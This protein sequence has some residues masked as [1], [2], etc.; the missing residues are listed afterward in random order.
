[1]M[2]KFLIALLFPVFGYSQPTFEGVVIATPTDNGTNTSQDWTVTIAGSGFT[3]V[4]GDLVLI[5]AWQ[6]TSATITVDVTGGQTWNEIGG[7]N[8]TNNVSMNTFW[9]EYNGTWSADPSLNFSAGTNTNAIMVVFRPSDAST[10]W[11]TEQISTQN[12]SA[13]ATITMT[14]VTP[15]FN[16]SATVAAWFTADDNTWG[17]LTGTGWSKTNLSAQYRNTSG[18]DMSGTFA[19]R[20]IGTAAA[21][22]DVSQTQTAV[23]N[24]A[25]CTRRITFYESAPATRRVTIIS[26]PK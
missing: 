6:R 9:C 17:S 1:M 16:N 7:D 22:N 24:D 21:T 11:A 19:Y 15:N 25:T 20:L 5:Y 23:G 2:K 4:T 3:F 12:Q 26:Q 14:G 18:N 8:G 13:A 10:T